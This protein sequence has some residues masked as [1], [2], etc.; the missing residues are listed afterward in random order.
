MY[1]NPL[2]TTTPAA[3]TAPS[4]S[5]SLDTGNTRG[6]G[7]TSYNFAI[8]RVIRVLRALRVLRAWK[9]IKFGTLGISINAF[10]TIFTLVTLIF[11]GSG[12]FIALEYQQ[13]IRF[14]EALY[15]MF[16]TISTIGYG[17]I[18][19]QTTEGQMFVVVF[20]AVTFVVIPKQIAKLRLHSRQNRL[21]HVYENPF[22]SNGHL[23]LCGHM[24][25]GALIDFVHE[26]Y[27]TSHGK[28]PLP[29]CGKFGGTVVC[30]FCLKRKGCFLMFFLFFGLLGFFLDFRCFFFSFHQF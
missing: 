11:C 28:Q 16:I 1:D 18:V 8:F 23:L 21:A 26:L 20:M 9:A 13:N 4:S 3:S 14:H 7:L 15:F 19:P 27:D 2:N 24:T 10:K 29:L 5:S 12:I 22:V 30:V 6:P 17:D 25:P